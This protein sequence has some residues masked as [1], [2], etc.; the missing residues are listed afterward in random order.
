MEIKLSAVEDAPDL[1]RYYFEN[2]AHLQPWEPLKDASFN[3]VYAWRVRLAGRAI[4]QR[5]GM[6][7][8]FLAY[9]ENPRHIMAT[10]SLTGITRGALQACFMGYSVA[11]RYEGQ[12]VMR[13]LCEYAIHHAFAELDLNRVMANYMPHNYR[14]GKLLMGLGFEK[15]GLAKRYLC[16]NGRWED[17][18]L[19]SLLNP[20]KGSVSV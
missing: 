6:S 14:S 20:R 9:G 7:R 12:G 3:S 18:V 1:Y 4:E 13:Q 19:T 2:A 11:E 5:E 8:Y 17:H 10:C 16:I 15:E